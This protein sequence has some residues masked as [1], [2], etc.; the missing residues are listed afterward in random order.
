MG[1]GALSKEREE[2]ISGG[3][4]SLLRPDLRNYGARLEARQIASQLYTLGKE[5]LEDL[6]IIGSASFYLWSSYLSNSKKWFRSKIS[7]QLR[8]LTWCWPF[9]FCH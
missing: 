6:Q 9:L 8:L 7:L 5:E 1:E 3:L 2:I 4:G